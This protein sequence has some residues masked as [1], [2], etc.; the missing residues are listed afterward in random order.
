MS[1][2][3]TITQFDLLIVENELTVFIKSQREWE[4]QVS[5]YTKDII[6]LVN[7]RSKTADFS[8]KKP[9]SQK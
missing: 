1:R 5:A 9:E 2:R 3:E 8:E 6:A 4:L 7:L